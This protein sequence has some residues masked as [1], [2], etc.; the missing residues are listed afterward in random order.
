MINF[1]TEKFTAE[2]AV[3]MGL[4]DAIKRGETT[5]SGRYECGKNGVLEFK[6]KT[7]VFTDKSG[8]LRIKKFKDDEEILKFIDYIKSKEVA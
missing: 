2:E 7:L 6:Q 5:F 8:S 4:Y 1:D 3:E